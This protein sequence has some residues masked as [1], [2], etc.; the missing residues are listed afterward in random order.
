MLIIAFAHQKLLE[1]SCFFENQE[2]LSKIH[3]IFVYSNT[4]LL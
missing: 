3:F 1:T 2:E 4:P